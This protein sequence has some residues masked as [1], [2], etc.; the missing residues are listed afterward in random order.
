MLK[1]IQLFFDILAPPYNEA[2]GRN[3]NYYSHK[4]VKDNVF[5]LQLSE[6]D[7]ICTLEPL[8]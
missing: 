4:K 7:F 1:K 2:E 6:P 5:N 8:D 3:C